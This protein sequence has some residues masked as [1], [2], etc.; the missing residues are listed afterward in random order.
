M[1]ALFKGGVR[2][3]EAEAGLMPTEEVGQAGISI[4][5]QDS[6]ILVTVSVG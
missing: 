2:V 4:W 3:K 1:H 5:S 6:L